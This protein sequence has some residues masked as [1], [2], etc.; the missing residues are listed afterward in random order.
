[1]NHRAT[2]FR[3]DGFEMLP[4]DR[5]KIKANLTKTGVFTYL[6]GEDEIKESRPDEEVFSADSLASLEGAYVT[7][8]H[9]QVPPK[10]VAIGRVL[11]VSADP[12]Y[13][14]GVLQVE[15]SRAAKMIE[16]GQLKEISCGY[17]TKL[18]KSDSEDADF[19][20]T[21][22][23]YD[24]TAIGPEGWGR[25]GRDVCLRLD[26]ENNQLVNYITDGETMP[27]DEEKT[28]EPPVEAVADS[29]EE[30]IDALTELVGKLITADKEP[31]PLYVEDSD[32][33]TA[34]QIKEQITTKV[35]D[36][37]DLE[38][39]AR[40][41]FAKRFPARHARSK[42]CGRDLCAAVIQTLDSGFV[43]DVAENLAHLVERAEDIASAYQ[44]D[45]KKPQQDEL[46]RAL[47][48]V[49]VTPE[50]STLRERILNVRS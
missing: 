45:S 35:Q 21:Q 41:A 27:P 31:A 14:S 39:R 8:D 19:I 43:G 28:P 7:I 23:R 2:S 20:Q 32:L 40:S 47:T 25:L 42:P 9:P 5:V 13:V 29:V 36:A 50:R 26:S 16:N 3:I 12:P 30:K 34:E 49:P 18:E 33:P 44:L 17:T 24:H 15:D 37:L 22:I 46:R 10:S 6:M 11:S 1:M 4:G 48:G 38:V